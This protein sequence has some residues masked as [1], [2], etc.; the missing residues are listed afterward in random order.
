MDLSIIIPVFNESNKIKEDINSALKFFN[1]EEMNGEIIVVDDGCTDGTSKVT[2]EFEPKQDNQVRTIRLPEH[3]GKGCAVREGIKSSK[4]DFVM[5]ADSGSCVPYENIL[6][7]LELIKSGECEIANGSRKLKDS[8]INTSQKFHRRIY[9]QVF[10]K[11]LAFYLKIP[12]EL[13][14]TQCGFKVYQGDIGRRLYSQ[15][16]SDGFMFDVEIIIR[17]LKHGYRIKEFPV[18]WTC[19]KDSRFSLGRSFWQLWSELRMIKHILKEK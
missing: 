7:G 12:T 9:S 19:D 16:I 14:D 15:S 17:A 4:G 1:K 18:D 2:A 10:R 6:I 8:Q 5:F 3:A 11:L 13:T